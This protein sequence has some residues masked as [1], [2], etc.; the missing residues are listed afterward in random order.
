M[1]AH[2]LDTIRYADHIVV[3]SNGVIIEEGDH[4]LLLTKQGQYAALWRLGK[5]DQTV[6][7]SQNGG[8]YV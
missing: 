7:V 8:S 1:I 2:R 4:E 6:D 5:Y 3:M